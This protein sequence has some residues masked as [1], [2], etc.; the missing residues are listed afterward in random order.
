MGEG[1]RRG[2]NKRSRIGSHNH[3]VVAEVLKTYVR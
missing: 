2:W 1:L 3:M